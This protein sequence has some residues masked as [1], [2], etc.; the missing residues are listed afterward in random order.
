MAEMQ[1]ST[2]IYSIQEVNVLITSYSSD[3]EVELEDQCVESALSTTESLER[4]L[5]HK[6]KKQSLKQQEVKQI[7]EYSKAVV[8]RQGFTEVLTLKLQTTMHSEKLKPWVEKSPV[9]ELKLLHKYLKYAFL[10]SENTLPI[11]ISS[12]LNPEQEAELL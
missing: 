3:S 9:L 7:Q 2:E 1:G 5:E 11:I 4:E 8:T 10:G 6:A 12:E